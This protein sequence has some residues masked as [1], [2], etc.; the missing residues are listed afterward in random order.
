M[1]TRFEMAA[2]YALW[3]ACL[4]WGALTGNVMFI[5]YTMLAAVVVHLCVKVESDD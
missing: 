5:V 4:L 2:F 3:A 1:V